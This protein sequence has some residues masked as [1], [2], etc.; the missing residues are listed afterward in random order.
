MS[1]CLLTLPCLQYKEAA[2][3]VQSAIQ[4]APSNARYRHSLGVIHEAAEQW[5]SAADAFERAVEKRPNDIKVTNHANQLDGEL[6]RLAGSIRCQYR[7]ALGRY[8]HLST[9]CPQNRADSLTFLAG[10]HLCSCS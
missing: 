8:S 10:K 9:T 6:V 7:P 2:R 1:L 3:L 5:S 4:L